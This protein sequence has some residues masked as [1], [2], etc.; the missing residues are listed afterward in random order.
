MKIKLTKKS[1]QN[2]FERTRPPKFKD[3]NAIKSVMS[4]LSLEISF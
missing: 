4:E 2:C 1:S 3:A